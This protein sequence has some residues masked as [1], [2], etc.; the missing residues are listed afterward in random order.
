MKITIVGGGISGLSAALVARDAGCE[1]ELIEA[2]DR[3]GGVLATE[4]RDGLLMERGPDSFVRTKPAAIELCERLNVDLIPTRDIPDRGAR[5]VKDGRLLPLPDG[6]ML[7]AP[8]KIWPFALSP[9]MSFGGKLRMLR[10]TSIPVREGASDTD[11][12]TLASF[13]RRRLGDEALDRLA[14]PLVAGIYSGDPEKLSLRA[15]MPRLLDMERKYGSLI[16]GMQAAAKGKPAASGAR[17]S[18]FQTPASGM[19]TVVD[20]LVERLQ[21]DGVTLTTGRRIESLDE[22]DGD[23]TVLALPARAAAALLDGDL[24]DELSAIRT[25]GSAT[26]SFSWPAEAVPAAKG[27][28]FVVP[29]I[30]DR[31]CMACTCAHNKYDG[32]APE[33]TALLRAFVGGALGPDVAALTDDEIITRA[34]DDLKE[35]LGIKTD[36]DVVVLSRYDSAQPQYEVGHLDR[37][38]RIEAA[39]TERPG[40]ELVGNSYR[41]VGVA[42]CIVS[43][44]RG[45]A[46][47]V[48]AP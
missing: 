45:I 2:C 39:V 14:Q 24:A 34:R 44:R 12:E 8:T 16:K 46:S 13:V 17:Y 28:G 38:A 27:Y 7:L 35:L 30:E 5:I 10:E 40:I 25:T 20:A 1:V 36:P 47:L 33:G 29:A 6:L 18:L 4:H 15:T 32:R 3:L 23:G 41:G 21:L 43:A 31:F 9:V 42:D 26:I 37:V 48:P 19:Q 11:D 22:L